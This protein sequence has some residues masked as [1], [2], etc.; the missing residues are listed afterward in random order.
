MTLFG[1]SS[2]DA[3]A[4]ETATWDGETKDETDAVVTLR[5]PSEPERILLNGD[6]AMVS[7]D[8]GA[9]LA[10]ILISSNDTG[11]SCENI[12][13][14]RF[15]DG[16]TGQL[17]TNHCHG[18]EIFDIEPGVILDRRLSKEDIDDPADD[19]PIDNQ[20]PRSRPLSGG[21]D[22]ADAGSDGFAPG[23]SLAFEWS[24][25]GFTQIP[26]EFQ[27]SGSG[28][29]DNNFKPNFSLGVPETDNIIW[30][31]ECIS[32]GKIRSHIYMN[33]PNQKPGDTASFKFET[34]QSLRT[35]SYP[36]RFV[37]SG[38]SSSFQITHSA[39]DPIFS[40]MQAGKWA[41]MQMGDGDGAA[42]IR[43]ALKGSGQS[44]DAFLP[45][46]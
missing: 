44:L 8:R 43:V 40:E 20:A 17:L 32:N 10:K 14:V 1:C 26:T 34:D 6:P 12:F 29:R 27:W 41:Y 5:L 15:K 45:A 3:T 23:T 24:A 36:A 33:I 18:D 37:D 4:P 42:K 46:C 16:S 31:S 13:S 28:R 7:I 11:W 9:G 22:T 2:Q 25:N 30:S 21:S 35:L 19:F 39:N 38:E